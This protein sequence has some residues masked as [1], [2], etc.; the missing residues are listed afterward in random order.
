MRTTRGHG[1]VPELADSIL[2][3]SLEYQVMSQYTA[4]LAVDRTVRVSPGG[5]DRTEVQPNDR[6]EGAFENTVEFASGSSGTNEEVLVVAK[7][8]PVNVGSTSTSEVITKDFLERLP[9]GRTYQSAVAM[10]A[11]VTGQGGN[12]N[13]CGGSTRQNTYMLDGANISD[14]VTGT[15]SVTPASSII[16]RSLSAARRDTKASP[17][18]R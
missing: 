17:A 2:A 16:A 13:I 10:A 1:E 18:P 9:T 8:S 15:F 6:P 12:K 11:G 4:F 3:T 7:R 14:P 5:P